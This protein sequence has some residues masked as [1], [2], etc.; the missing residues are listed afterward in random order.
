M[1]ALVAGQSGATQPVSAQEI[2]ALI[3]KAES[4]YID[5]SLEEFMT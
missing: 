1:V 3:N 2:D 5:S 4:E